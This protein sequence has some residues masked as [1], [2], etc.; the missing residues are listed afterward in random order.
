MARDPLIVLAR[1]RALQRDEAQRGMAAAQASLA[2]AEQAARAAGEAFV[3]EAAGVPVADYAAWLPAARR[4]RQLAGEALAGA[5]S[6][7]EVARLAL[8]TARAEAEAVDQLR[9]AQRAA[10]RRTREQREQ[11]R[12]EEAGGGARVAPDALADPAAM[13]S[14][15]RVVV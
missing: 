2:G 6:M 13:G 7:A 9:S 12:L 8:L 3:R 15:K 5:E 4:E 14:R 1:L 11:Q 10:R